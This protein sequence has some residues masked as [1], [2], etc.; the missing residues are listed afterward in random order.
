LPLDGSEGWVLE[1]VSDVKLRTF[2]PPGQQLECE[3][4]LS[5][6]ENGQAVLAVETRTGKRVL[7]GAR[8]KLVA[9][10]R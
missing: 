1:S 8:V 9:K 6:H 10:A 7:G 3:A 5:R 4:R 2:I